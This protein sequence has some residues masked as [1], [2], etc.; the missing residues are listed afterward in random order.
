MSSPFFV[1]KTGH[2]DEHHRLL[3]HTALLPIS[4]DATTTLQAMLDADEPIMLPEGDTTISDTLTLKTGS[5]II[6]GRGSAS[7]TRLVAASGFNGPMLSSTDASRVTL[8]SFGLYGRSAS[9]SKGI[10]STGGSWWSMRDLVFDNFGD[11]A[12]HITAGQGHRLD[13]PYAQNCLLDRSRDQIDGV[14]DI[15]ATD[16]VWIGGEAT[17]SIY[18]PGYDWSVGSGLYDQ[19][20]C[21]AVAMRGANSFLYGV[22]AEISQIG[23]Y[24]PAGAG[25][26]AITMTDCRA[27]LNQGE[28]F[29]IGGTRGEFVSCLSFRNGRDAHNTYD[30]FVN[31]GR[32][33][34]FVACR[35]AD[36]GEDAVK[37]RHAHTDTVASGDATHYVACRKSD[38]Q[39]NLINS[40]GAVTALSLTPA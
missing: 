16:V 28:G 23:F 21:A 3:R 40:T 38:I 11:H 32:A 31:T 15:A 7:G 6:G 17:A 9:G 5:V 35:T 10:Y 33:N 18:P 20:R 8:S 14:I 34:S 27:D 29:I 25:V 4:G 22:V 12:I 37:Q 39:G 30:G 1:G 24:V 19:G 36:L 26:Y 13:N 2:I